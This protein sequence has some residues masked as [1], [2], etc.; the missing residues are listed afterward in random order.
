MALGDIPAREALIAP[1][2]VDR[3]IILNSVLP[4]LPNL[5]SINEDPISMVNA[6][7]SKLPNPM[8]IAI[9]IEIPLPLP[10]SLA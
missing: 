2:F 5:V 4:K 7:A 9:R 8:S 3:E 1:V 10:N 6:N